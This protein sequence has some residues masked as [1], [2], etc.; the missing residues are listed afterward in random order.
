MKLVNPFYLDITVSYKFSTV[1][2]EC[3]SF[4]DPYSGGLYEK[5]GCF[6]CNNL[7]IFKRWIYSHPEC[8]KGH[9]LNFFYIRKTEDG[10][11]LSTCDEFD[12]GLYNNKFYVNH[13]CDSCIKSYKSMGTLK[14]SL[15]HKIVKEIFR[16]G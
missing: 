12:A 7:N 10:N 16:V 5:S 15:K 8:R 9:K 6:G 3:E 2:T 1:V 14:C 11:I 13:G 4:L